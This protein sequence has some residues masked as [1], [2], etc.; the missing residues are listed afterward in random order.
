RLLQRALAFDADSDASGYLAIVLVR[1]KRIADAIALARDAERRDGRLLVVGEM[2]EHTP[3]ARPAAPALLDDDTVRDWEPAGLADLVSTVARHAP[4]ALGAVL[5]RV[6]A[7][8][9][10]VPYLY[11]ASF[12]VERPQALQIL[13]RVLALPAPEREAGEARTAFVMAWNNA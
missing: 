1:Q 2:A 9:D 7:E 11:N 3:N 13:R 4:A 6:P 12:S 5:E 8:R 10:L